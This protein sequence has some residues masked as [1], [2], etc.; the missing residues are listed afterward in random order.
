M[1]TLRNIALT[2]PYFHNGS[3]P[4]LPEALE[5]MAF[6]NLGLEIPKEQ[7]QDLIAFLRTLTGEKPAILDEG[8][9]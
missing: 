9:R 3:C 7:E 5:Q 4:S 6:H 8:S 1:P 2:A